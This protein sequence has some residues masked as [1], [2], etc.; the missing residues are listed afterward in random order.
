MKM[1]RIMLSPPRSPR[2]PT[3]VFPPGNKRR[4]KPVRDV[5]SS[6]VSGI[7]FSLCRRIQAI[8]G[9]ATTPSNCDVDIEPQTGKVLEFI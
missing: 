2:R 3:S 1:Y 6:A 8:P 5:R 7:V 4:K 9:L